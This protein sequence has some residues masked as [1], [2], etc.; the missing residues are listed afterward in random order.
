MSLSAEFLAPS[1]RTSP[2]MGAPPRTSMCLSSDTIGASPSGSS[3]AT[4]GRTLVPA[5]CAATSIPCSCNGSTHRGRASPACE[6]RTEATPLAG[7]VASTAQL[8]RVPLL[9]AFGHLEL[10]LTP[11]EIELAGVALTL[12]VRGDVGQPLLVQ[13]RVP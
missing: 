6:V 4:H 8:Y 9:G 10:R 2:E 5:G 7:S 13:A 3:S 11:L 1:T 12:I